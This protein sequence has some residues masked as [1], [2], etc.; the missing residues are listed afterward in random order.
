MTGAT[1]VVTPTRTFAPT[2]S[3]SAGAAFTV[4]SPA[5]VSPSRMTISVRCGK[6]SPRGTSRKIPAA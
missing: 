2:S 6:R 4:S 1:T 5:P 3:A